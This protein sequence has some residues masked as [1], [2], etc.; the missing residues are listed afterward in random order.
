MRIETYSDSLALLRG[1][2]ALKQRGLTAKGILFLALSAQG[3]IYLAIPDN[4]DQMNQLEQLGQS[5]APGTT[6][7]HP[8]ATSQSA[9]RVGEKLALRWPEGPDVPSRLF[10][11]DSIH[12][13]RDDFYV[14]NGD[15]RLSQSGNAV[16]VGSV[17]DGDDGYDVGDPVDDPEVTTACVV[18]PFQVE[19]KRLPDALW[20]ARQAPVD[21]LDSGNGH[22]LRE[23][24][25]RAFG[26][27]GPR[28]LV[29]GRHQGR[30]A[31]RISS[32]VRTSASPAAISARLSRICWIS[33]GRL[34]TSRVSSREA[35]SSVLMTTAAG[36]P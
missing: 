29:L 24:S 31:A 30:I 20:V 18:K 34:T 32:L 13:L 25:Q 35:R 15:R 26:R 11:F 3:R 23:S 6:P 17:V 12:A 27:R 8:S 28:D 16:D 1:L 19:P 4:L 33:F 5:P 10:H 22:L 2:S 21:G 36:L 14:V 7:Q 9:L